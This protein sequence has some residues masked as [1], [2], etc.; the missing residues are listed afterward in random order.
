MG[1]GAGARS[2]MPEGAFGAR[3]LA[4]SDAMHQVLSIYTQN[5]T[6]RLR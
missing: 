5:V 3:G 2:G 4:V 6:Q 1:T